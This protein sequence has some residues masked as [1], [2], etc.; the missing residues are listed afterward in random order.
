MYDVCK[1]GTH[2]LGEISEKV[3]VL[4]MY[5]LFYIFANLHVSCSY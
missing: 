5:H 3:L 1:Q 2:L 4:F